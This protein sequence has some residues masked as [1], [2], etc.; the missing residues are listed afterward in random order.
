MPQVERVLVKQL[1]STCCVLGLPTGGG[2]IK[3]RSKGVPVV[4]Q[5]VRNPT[6]IHVNAGLIPG[7]S[8]WVTDPELPQAGCRCSSDLT[9]L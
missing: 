2:G 1:F 6:R 7:L 4:A 9:L 8:Q 3:R 5:W